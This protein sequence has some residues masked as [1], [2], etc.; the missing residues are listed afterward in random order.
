[1]AIKIT[2]KPNTTGATGE[3]P[4]GNIKDNT[5]GNT[6][7][8]INKLV[9][10]DFHQFFARLMAKATEAD[11]TF[12][13]NNVPDDAYQGFQYFEALGLAINGAWQN[14]SYS[15]PYA[16][17][18][19][20]PIQYRLFGT[21]NVQIRGKLY[22]ATPNS[23]SIS[24]TLFTLPTAFRPTKKQVFPCTNIADGVSCVIEVNTNGTVQLRGDLVTCTAND[25]VYLNF[26]FT[27]N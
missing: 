4:Y 1:M 14:P 13:Y 6:G 5:G 17:D 18:P 26:T 21:K 9:M 2:D 25:S 11:A 8:P 12:D 3:F 22:D 16:A 27:L 7:T 15:A 20:N 19:S 23:V 24:E 10:A